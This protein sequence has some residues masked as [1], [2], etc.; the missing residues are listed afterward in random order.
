MGYRVTSFLSVSATDAHE[1]FFY[2]LPT[3]WFAYQWI[4]QWVDTNFDVLASR[5]GPEAV[6]I[7]APKGAEQDFS[8]EGEELQY[9]LQTSLQTPGG[10][11][12][13]DAD[14]DPE[15]AL[16][17]GAP[18]LIIS[19]HPLQPEDELRMV[20]CA[21]VNLAAY[22]ENTLATLFDCALEAIERGEDPVEVIPVVSDVTDWRRF[23]FLKA[24]ELK[25][26][27]FGVGIN[28]NAVIDLLGEWRNHRK[29]RRGA[30]EPPSGDS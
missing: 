9:R 10:D 19:R 8:R 16:H 2:Y 11:L 1:A 14:A 29:R 24:L 26:N 27:I 20:N 30:A 13:G 23:R 3:R 22:D 6:L 28:G 18:V 21:V 12:L 15:E 7:T 25:P 5:F 4:N 17:A